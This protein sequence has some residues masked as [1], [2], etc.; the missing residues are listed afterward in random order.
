MVEDKV[1][2]HQKNFLREVLIKKAS[3]KDRPEDIF[4]C[5]TNKMDQKAKINQKKMAQLRLI[6]TKSRTM[7]IKHGM[8]VSLKGISGI[9]LIKCLLR[10]I[11]I[12]KELF[13]IDIEQGQE[14]FIP[15]ELSQDHLPLSFRYYDPILMMIQEKVSDESREHFN[16]QNNV[17]FTLHRKGDYLQDFLKKV[18]ITEDER[19][20]KLTYQYSS[21]FNKAPTYICHHG[22]PH[23]LALQRS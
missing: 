19:D 6:R 17:A 13:I 12:V 10:K 3:E 14:V 2:D 21:V 20:K 11:Q 15:K 4:S 9:A 22:S 1:I 18:G 16:I 8:A 5:N 23:T 7:L